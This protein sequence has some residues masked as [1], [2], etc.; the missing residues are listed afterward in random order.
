MQLFLDITSSILDAFLL[1]IFFRTVLG[2]FRWNLRFFYV[3]SL[4]GVEII[5]YANQFILA[6]TNT[7][8]MEKEITVILSILT[9][10][11]LSLFFKAKI[12]IHLFYAILLQLLSALADSIFTWLVSHLQPD[13]LTIDDGQLLFATMGFGSTITLFFLILLFNL[14]KTIGGHQYPIR[15]HIMLLIMPVITLLAM[16]SIKARVFFLTDNTDFYCIFVIVLTLINMINYIEIEWSSRFLNDQD[17]LRQMEQQINYQKEKYDQLSY[18]YRQSRSFLHDIRKHFFTMQEYLH[19]GRTSELSEYIERSFGDLQQIY[20]RY[21]TGNLVIDSFITNYST[22]AEQHNVR[23]EAILHVD[24]KRIPMENYDLCVVL[25]NLL[26]NAIKA[27]TI[28][29]NAERFIMISIETTKDDFFLIQQNNSM[30]ASQLLSKKQNEL[31]HGFGLKNIARTLDRYHGL[32]N[33]SC[34]DLFSMIIRVPITDPKQ[35]IIDID[36]TPPRKKNE[37]RKA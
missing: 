26:D 35:R 30:D 23:F 7:A 33:Y 34:G 24:P 32:M 22:I 3:I 6:S 5:L 15:F 1:T 20:A 10:F 12:Y 16:A 4:V 25:G 9:T 21:N 18:S 36:P 27:S 13:L 17:K 37:F 29:P 19:E 14:I 28:T 8:G 31:D 11:L 2:V